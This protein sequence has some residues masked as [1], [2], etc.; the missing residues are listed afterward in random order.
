MVAVDA[1]GPAGGAG[2]AFAT[3]TGT[4]TH[5]NNGN[6]IVV[7]V[8]IFTGSDTTTAVSYGGV[9]LSKIGFSFTGTVT[10]SGGISFWGRIGGLPTG[11]NTVS[12]TTTDTNN[13]NAG[14][15]SF[16]AA[17]SFGT[18]FLA[19]SGNAAVTS[20]A[21]TVNGTHTGG[22]IVTAACHGAS[23]TWGL[24]G[25]TLQFHHDTSS[26]AASDNIGGGTA[27]STGG[28]ANQ[29]ITWTNTASD[30]FGIVAVE[31]LPA[32]GGSPSQG[33]PPAQRPGPLSSRLGPGTPFAQP[34]GA[35]APA[36]GGA[37]AIGL[38]DPAGV[39]DALAVSAAAPLGDVAGATEALSAAAAVPVADVTGAIDSLSVTV[40]APLADAAGAVESSTATV[41]ASLADVAGA[42]DA[43]VVSAAL[44]VADVAAA[45]DT[46]AV[47]QPIPQADVAAAIDALAVTSSAP[48]ADVAGAVEILSVSTTENF[49]DAAGAV[50]TISVA[51]QAA[52]ADAAGAVDTLAATAAVA[53]PEQ[54][55]AVDALAAAA[56]VPLLEVTGAADTIAV[57]VGNVVAWPETGAAVDSLAVTASAA[58]SD[59]AGAAEA[60]TVTSSAGLADVAG[61]TDSLVVV[62][63][64]AVPLA[65]AAGA[66]DALQ[67]AVSVPL[68]DSAAAVELLVPV[69]TLAFSDLAGTVEFFHAFTG[70][71]LPPREVWQLQSEVR[72]R[73]GPLAARW[74]AQ[75]ETGRW[76]AEMSHAR[77][78][79]QPEPAR[80]RIKMT[81][82]DPIA[83]LSEE[84]IPIRWTS[85]LDGTV[86]DPTALVCQY[87]LP[88]SSGNPASPAQPVTWFTGTWLT[89]GTGKGFVQ[90]CPTGPGSTG[91]TLV[92]GQR[93]DVWGFIQGTPEAPKKYAGTVTVY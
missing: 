88:V 59:V 1:V 5:V 87:A 46:V 13:K 4:W 67:V 86:I 27:V 44:A 8:T 61:V 31:V 92:V 60:L 30:E 40:S 10:Q 11:S 66:V 35:E 15:I 20:L 77:W 93:Y 54:A 51:L 18:A 91:P 83:A 56:A 38:A 39:I 78:A 36:G 32:S 14:S 24:T 45:I 90:L 55:G 12:V 17:G 48:L 3:L 7:G 25:G 72:W 22:L 34:R 75:P 19:N 63:G 79:A 73:A 80:W 41:T 6:G 65:D 70:V 64:T 89:G 26:T 69:V 47:S 43:P 2:T 16:S 71:V 21:V 53:L 9:A 52:Y 81:A 29:T 33:F 76:R 28:G 62:T 50:D 85:D 68:S 82:F 84:N 42:A 23:T 49:T 57:V 74:G 58:L 37:S